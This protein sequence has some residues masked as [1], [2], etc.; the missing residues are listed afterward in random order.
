MLR[1]LLLGTA[2]ATFAAIGSANAVLID[3]FNNPID[4]SNEVFL[5][6]AAA[7]VAPNG[8]TAATCPGGICGPISNTYSPGAGFGIIGGERTISSTGAGLR[9]ILPPSTFSSQALVSNGGTFTHSQT[10]GFR[11]SSTILWAGA[12]GAGLGADLTADGSSAFHLNVVAADLAAQWRLVLTDG[13]STDF[14]QFGTGGQTSN[15]DLFVNFASFTGIDFTNIVSIAFVANA[16]FNDDFDTTVD[17][18][19]TVPEPATMTLLGA[20]LAGIGFL[21]RRRRKAA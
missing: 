14:V 1:N 18:L 6:S 8:G 21:A 11:T 9:P 7:P 3:N 17:I 13:D 2:L 19:E 15:F 20:G 4:G 16:T 5:S 12:G 10:T